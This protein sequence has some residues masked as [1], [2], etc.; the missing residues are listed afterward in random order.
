MLTDSYP[1]KKNEQD[2]EMCSDSL[3]SSITTQ[4]LLQSQKPTASS[5]ENL[6]DSLPSTSQTVSSRTTIKRGR[7]GSVTPKL[8]DSSLDRNQLS[9]SD[10]VYILQTIVDVPANEISFQSINLLSNAFK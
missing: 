5:K 8:V 7:K 10:S 2:R 1:R 4:D 9:I 3:S 6:A